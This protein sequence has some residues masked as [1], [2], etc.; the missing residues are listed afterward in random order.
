MNVEID[1]DAVARSISDAQAAADRIPD[2]ATIEIYGRRLRPSETSGGAVGIVPNE[3]RINGERVLVPAGAIMQVHDVSDDGMVS[4]TVTMF[5]KRL[6][7]D[8]EPPA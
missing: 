6:V 1:G 4:V 3:L 2:G 5:V 7:M 8:A